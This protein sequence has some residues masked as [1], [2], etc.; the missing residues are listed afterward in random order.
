M[1]G[2]GLHASTV[3]ILGCGRIGFS[4]LRKLQSFDPSRILYYSRSEKP[5]GLLIFLKL[6]SHIR[7]QLLIFCSIANKLGAELKPL[8]VIMKESDFIV[9][10]LSQTPK[11]AKIINKEMI[12]LMKP[13]AII[14]N[15]GRGGK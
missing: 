1:C 3:G 13:T 15:I 14:V 12:C 8:D 11:T 9:L 10:A 5:E 4:I 2:Y 6:E 7:T